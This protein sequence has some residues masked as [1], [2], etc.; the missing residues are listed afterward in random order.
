MVSYWLSCVFFLL[1]ELVAG[2]GEIFP[3][4][5]WSSKVDFCWECKICLLLL[6]P[7]TNNVWQGM[8]VPP[9]GFLTP[10]YMRFQTFVCGNNPYGC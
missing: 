3:A 9:S 2:Q 7:A 10:F 1:V 4:S 5:R 6:E 8:K